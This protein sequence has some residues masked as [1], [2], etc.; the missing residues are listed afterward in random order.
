MFMYPRWLA[1][2][3]SWPF[4][5][6]CDRSFLLKLFAPC[7]IN[8]REGGMRGRVGQAGHE[9]VVPN[10]SDRLRVKRCYCLRSSQMLGLVEMQV[11][12]SPQHRYVE[13]PSYQKHVPLQQTHP[14]KKNL[15]CS[16]PVRQN[17]I[18][19]RPVHYLYCSKFHCHK[20]CMAA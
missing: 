3:P 12:P 18:I 9:W 17:A 14:S 2:L 16:G 6:Y 13:P 10:N 1:V 11:P 5:L 7:N 19:C 15:A 8:S 4:L 20:K